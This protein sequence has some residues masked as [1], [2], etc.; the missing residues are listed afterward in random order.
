MVTTASREH[1][2]VEEQSAVQ[3]LAKYWSEGSRHHLAMA[4]AGGLLRA[5][6][7]QAAVERFL[8]E[9]AEAAGD[10]EP[11]TRAAVVA[12]TARKLKADEA[13]VTGFPTV[14]KLIGRDGDAVV[15]QI[16]VL[17]G[18]AITLEQLAL[19]KALPVEFLKGLGLH[20]LPQGGVGIPY[21]SRGGQEVVKLR[22]SLKAGDGSYWPKGTPL[23]SYGEER[24]ESAPG[25]LLLVE[26]ESDCWTLWHHGLPALGL[27]GA[28]TVHKTLHVGHVNGIPRIYVVQETDEAGPQF[29]ANVANRLRDIGWEGDARVVSLAPAKDANALHKQGPAKFHD[30][31]KAAMD[32]AEPLPRTD[33]ESTAPW[34]NL[35]P[36]SEIPEVPNFPVEVLPVALRSL[37]EEIA[38]A[39]NLPVDMAA[40]PLLVMA[41][42]ALANSRHLA[43]TSTHIQSACLFG[44]TVCRPGSGKSIPPRIL[45]KPFEEIQFQWLQEWEAAMAVWEEAEE[46]ERGPRP[47]PRRCMVDDVTTESLK[48][49]LLDNP[50]GVCGLTD[51]VMSL[52]AGFNQY[53]GGRGNDR[54]F[55]LKLWAGER[56]LADR[57]SEK[58]LRGAP[59]FILEPFC[60]LF[61]TTQP[62]MLEAMRG[63]YARGS[64]TRDDGFFDR[65]LLSYS[66]ELPDV[67]ET[68]RDVTDTSRAAWKSVVEKLIG[69]EMSQDGGSSRPV[70]VR[71]DTNGRRAWEDFTHAHAAEKN[72]SDFPPNLYGPWSK[73]KGYGARLALVLHYLRW[74]CGEVT[75]E[76]VDGD[77]V[78]KAAAL[79]TYFKA[80]AKKV[81]A[82]LGTDARLRHARKAVQWI[83]DKGAQQFSKRDIYQGLKGTFKTVEDLEPVLTILDK[84]GLIRPKV[85]TDRPGPG[86]KP[87]PT[88]EVHPQIG[89]IDPHNSHNPQNGTHGGDAAPSRSDSGDCEDCGDQQRKLADDPRDVT[90]GAAEWEEGEVP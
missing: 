42:G 71:L 39:A 81:H 45:G 44:A 22:V 9:V 31:F 4:V 21:R 89:A 57:K 60:S 87:S 88:Y 25:Y 23:S 2:S 37:V 70:R 78:T 50:R 32:R 28:K 20:D 75:H 82:C 6:Y 38:W 76:Q 29:I 66:V 15:C 13:H 27:P 68:W 72:V 67:G 18:V 40:V 52:F 86:R 1:S 11:Q 59:I 7:E 17:L 24:L 14:A 30:H 10:T 58:R 49:V 74:A 12:P 33:G 56:I 36:L 80:H 48:L 46:D 26:G 83:S 43:I 90:A 77:S 65:F 51:E 19:H 54:Q 35:I 69:L 8:E 73:L 63:E 55:F 61:G 3:L 64:T 16:K 47:I 53:K 34:P 84:H 62:D 85:G 79:V 41:G 5:G